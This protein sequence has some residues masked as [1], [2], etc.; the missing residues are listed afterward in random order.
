MYHAISF[1]GQS[2]IYMGSHTQAQKARS[3]TVTEKFYYKRSPGALLGIAG[4]FSVV[5]FLMHLP[6]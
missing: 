2:K 5:S 3:K 1:K 6:M 4:W